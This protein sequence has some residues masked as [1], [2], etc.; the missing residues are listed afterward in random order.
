MGPTVAHSYAD[1]GSYEVRL[2]VT[3][4]DGLADTATTVVTVANAPPVLTS[5]SGPLDPVAVGTAVSVGAAFTDAGVLDTHTASVGWGDG[6][7][8]AAAVTQGPGAGTLGATHTYTSAG[9]YSVPVTLGD[10]DGGSATDAF[11]YAVA[12]DPS[13]GFVTGGGWIESPVGAYASDPSASGRAS[14]GFVSRY[15]QG[16]QRPEG[17]TQFRMRMADLTFHSELYDWLVVAGARA[18]FKGVGA[19]NGESG[20]GFMLTAVDGQEPGGG[21]A[22]RFRIKIWRLATEG[23]VYDNQRGSSDDAE[24]VTSLGGGQIQIHR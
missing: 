3:N 14:F 1:D 4:P 6:S 24:P 15:R 18:Q 20:Y 7:T 5:L 22:D 21:G 17:E 11:Q 19:L 16:A 23:V 13:G 2:T 9:V 8:T 12:Y 10:D